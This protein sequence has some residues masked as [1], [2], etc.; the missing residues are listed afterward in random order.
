MTSGLNK[1]VLEI[2]LD[3]DQRGSFN[4]SDHD[5][6]RVMRKIGLDAR[7]GVHAEAVQICPNGRGVIL[8]TLKPEV[9]VSF[10]DKKYL[11]LL[12]LVSGPSTSN[13]LVRGRL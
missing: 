8:I 7:P 6:A 4:V 3:K 13:Q 12:Q 2:V 1:N 9:P 11:R 5:C 10:V